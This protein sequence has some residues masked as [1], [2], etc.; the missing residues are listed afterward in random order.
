M[1]QVTKFIKYYTLLKDSQLLNE[2]DIKYKGININKKAGP[3]FL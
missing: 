2:I 1:I 3:T